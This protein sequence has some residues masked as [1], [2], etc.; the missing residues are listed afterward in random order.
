MAL[1]PLVYGQPCF[2]S[3]DWSFFSFVVVINTQIH[4]HH[5]QEQRTL[6]F[7]LHSSRSRDPNRH[8]TIITNHRQMFRTCTTRRK[9][10]HY[11]FF[12][13]F[14]FFFW[15]FTENTDPATSSGKLWSCK[16]LL[17]LPYFAKCRSQ[18]AWRELNRN[19]RIAELEIKCSVIKTECRNFALPCS[20][21]CERFVEFSLICTGWIWNLLDNLVDLMWKEML[22]SK[23]FVQGIYCFLNY[24]REN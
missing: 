10:Q 14:T 9:A 23:S 8:R 5:V 1:K 7:P 18:V 11:V 24:F 22:V 19:N 15:G 6:Y 13:Y 12:K 2:K 16:Q 3:F 20:A 4:K 21:L 17:T